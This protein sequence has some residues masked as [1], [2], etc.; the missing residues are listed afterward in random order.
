M[1]SH[2]E[3]QYRLYGL[4][5]ARAL[6]IFGMAFIHVIMMISG[7]QIIQSAYSFAFDWFS[8]RPAAVFMVLAGLGISLRVRPS[9]SSLSN[10]AITQNLVKRGVFFFVAGFLNVVFWQGDILRVYGIAYLMGA[11]LLTVKTYWLGILVALFPL[12]FFLMNLWL[13]FTS[14]WDFNTLEYAN[15][16]TLQ[17]AVMNLFF[18]G[19]RA[20]FPW[21]GLFFLGMIVGR[22][23][24]GDKRVV[25][26]LL[27]YSVSVMVIAELSSR[28]IL[29]S[30]LPY[31]SPEEV[32]DVLAV[33]GTLSLPAMP[34]F[35]LSAGGLALSVIMLCL[36][37][38][39]GVLQG[40]FRPLSNVGQLAFTWYLLHIT[41][42]LLFTLLFSTPEGL[43]LK[44]GVMLWAGLCVFMLVCSY[45]I[46]RDSRYGPFE[47]LLRAATR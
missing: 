34:F 24:L 19:F 43:T 9:S 47:W 37:L 2:S 8:G 45:A 28:V 27:V 29:E 4:D 46:K 12:A 44:S 10:Q 26:R 16:W 11:A 40:L 32:E 5:V 18:N 30:L 42:I 14:N 36:L 23:N 3:K 15:L 6:A 41:I 25:R 33:F 22:L 38:P 35:I 20:V 7:E 17:G 39:G 13:D 1:S 31:T 21:L